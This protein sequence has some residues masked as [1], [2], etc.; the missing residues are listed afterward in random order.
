MTMIHENATIMRVGA[1]I[2]PGQIRAFVDRNKTR[3]LAEMSETIS[4]AKVEFPDLALED[5]CD[6]IVSDVI[7]DLE[8]SLT[9]GTEITVEHVIAAAKNWK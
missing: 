8:D 5:I 4:R 6:G 9:S 1:H 2:N 7:F 3:I